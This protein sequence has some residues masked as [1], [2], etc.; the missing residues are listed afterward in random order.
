MRGNPRR[1][2]VKHGGAAL[3]VGY[4]PPV[5]EDVVAALRLRPNAVL[6]GVKYSCALFKEIEHVW[7]Q[8]LE[9]AKDIRKKALGPVYIHGRPR[10]FQRNVIRA[11]PGE[12]W[13]LDFVWPDLRW[14]YG[15]SGFGA[16]LWARWGLGFDEVILC[17]VPMEFGGYALQMNGIKKPQAAFGRSFAERDVLD[18]WKGVIQGFIADGRAAGITSMSGWTREVLGAPA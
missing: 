7:T 14:I 13:M 18:R 6:L 15:S 5:Y 4:A 9:Q 11:T 2:S 16:A 8:H 3:V 17:G 1:Y 12:N 10:E